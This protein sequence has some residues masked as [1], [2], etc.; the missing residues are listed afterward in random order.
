MSLDNLLSPNDLNLYC[1]SITTSGVYSPTTNTLDTRLLNASQSIP[2][3]SSTIADFAGRVAPP[4]D[5]PTV[6]YTYNNGVFTITGDRVVITLTLQIK[7]DSGTN[8]TVGTRSVL[9]RR[10]GDVYAITRNAL[11]GS[12]MATGD[13]YCLPLT[14]TLVFT[15]GETFQFEVFQTSGGALNMQ[16]ITDSPNS[17]T[18]LQ[19]VATF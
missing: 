6:P 7:W 4:T 18:Y 9:L 12:A 3:N 19:I 16:G 14:A 8:P 13:Y 15:V 10:N 1:G 17:F 5:Q 11:L 2:N